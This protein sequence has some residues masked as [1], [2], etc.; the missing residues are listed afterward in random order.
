MIEARLYEKLPESMVRCHTCQWRCKIQ[1][2]KTGVCKMYKN[3]G[4]TLFNMNYA[5]ASSIA[6]DPVEKK[7]LF[8]LFPGSLCFSL[9]GWGCNF[10]CIHCQNWEISCVNIPDAERGT[11]EVLPQKAVDLAIEHGCR[12]IAWTYNEP[13]MWFEYTLDSA[14]IAH[15]AGLYS[16]YVT[17]GYATEEAL[18]LLGPY[19]TAWRVDVKGF[20]DG[21]YSKLAR[22][23]HW[24]GILDVAKRAKEK[25]GMHVEVITNIIPGMNDDDAQLGGIAKWIASD[26]GGLTP[27][28]VTRFYPQYNLTDVPATPVAT[29]EKAISLG[30]KEGLKFIY[31]GNIPGHSSENTVCYNCH[32]LIVRRLGYEIDVLGLAGTHCKFCGAD[33][34][35]RMDVKGVAK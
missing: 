17:N 26:L 33:L 35:F 28:H 13:T 16:V 7:P 23:S 20:S 24:R 15:A 19:L 14:K 11:T 10:H 9:G 25:W 3:E 18:D 32:N 2:D 22:I 12:G 27:W 8:H 4:G 21:F 34:N 29:I 5:R 6:V 1:P 31:G 30:K